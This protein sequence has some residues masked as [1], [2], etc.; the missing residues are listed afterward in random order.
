MFERTF[1]TH[2]ILLIQ[3]VNQRHVN[4]YMENSMVNKSYVFAELHEV[5]QL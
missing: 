3:T 1:T 4:T 5:N 2:I